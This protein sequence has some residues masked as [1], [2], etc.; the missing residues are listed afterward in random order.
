MTTYLKLTKICYT[1]KVNAHFECGGIVRSNETIAMSS[2]CLLMLAKSY[3]M[4]SLLL[5]TITNC[6]S[7]NR[8]RSFN[9]HPTSGDLESE[10]GYLLSGRLLHKSTEG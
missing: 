3:L 9:L 4:A 8:K 1:T 5:V 10:V 2:T 7:Q 6:S